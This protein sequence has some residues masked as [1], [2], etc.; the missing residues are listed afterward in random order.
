M[1][2]LRGLGVVNEELQ[3]RQGRL[4][5]ISVDPPK[6]SL[7]VVRKQG[8]GFSILSDEDRKVIREYGIVHEG[9]GPNGGDI[10]VPA[11]FLIDRD[12]KL[13]WFHRAVRITDRA[14]PSEVLKIIQAL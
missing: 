10:A 4:L 1:W 3:R 11:M 9:G 8:L 14:L 13:V 12:G 6:K 5:A 2:E 7:R